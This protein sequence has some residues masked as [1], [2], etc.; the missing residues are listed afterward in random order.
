MRKLIVMGIALCLPLLAGA[1][2]TQQRTADS[3]A[4]IKAFF[5]ELKGELEGAM[6]SGGPVNAIAV[7]NQKAPGIAKQH[8]AAKGWG[9][10]RT[11]LKIRNPANT[12]DAWEIHV[13]KRFEERKAA[14]EK[15]DQLEHAEIVTEGGKREFR[16]MKAIPTAEVC[17]K[18][19]GATVP[20]EV[21]AKLQALYPTDQARGY[22]PG[23]LRGAFTIRQPM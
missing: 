15:P 2:E 8:S 23:D 22:Q 17:T 21:E 16:Y 4:V 11:S 20:A 5:G 12:P 14:G 3:R 1:D 10:G 6:K 9:V 13:L 19:H 7:C 18:C